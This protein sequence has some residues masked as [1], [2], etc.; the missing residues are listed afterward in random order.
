MILNGNVSQPLSALRSLG[1]RASLSD[2]TPRS[3]T[4]KLKH[5]KVSEVNSDD[6]IEVKLDGDCI[7]VLCLKYVHFSNAL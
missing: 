7:D 5:G 6:V 1:K 3:Y 4:L 2:V